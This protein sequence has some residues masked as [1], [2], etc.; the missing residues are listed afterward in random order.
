[1]VESSQERK[2]PPRVKEKLSVAQTLRSQTVTENVQFSSVQFSSLTD[3]VVG[4]TRR[5]IQQ[6]SSACLL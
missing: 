2:K 6:I 5:T 1:M 3:R 4:G